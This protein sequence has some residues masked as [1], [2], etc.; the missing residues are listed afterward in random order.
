VHAAADE[1]WLHSAHDVAEGGMAVALAECAL[2][3]P[4]RLGA[5][6]DLEQGMRA[7]VLL[8]GESQSRILLSLDRQSWPRLR[9]RAQREGIPVEVIGEVAGDRLE[10]G[11]WIDLAVVDLAAAWEGALERALGVV[12]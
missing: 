12:A 11:D 2:A 6:V 1:G 10:I 3:S 8:F 4:G 9:D 7:D 5:R